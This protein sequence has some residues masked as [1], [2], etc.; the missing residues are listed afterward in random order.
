MGTRGA[1]RK[2]AIKGGANARGRRS[3]SMNG[4]VNCKGELR[5]WGNVRKRSLETIDREEGTL[6]AQQTVYHT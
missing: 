4:S 5:R 3:Q 1:T 6:R 2:C